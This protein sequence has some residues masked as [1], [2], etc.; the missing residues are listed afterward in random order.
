MIRRLRHYALSAINHI[1]AG[2]KALKDTYC[3]L[4]S[5]RIR[6]ATAN[7]DEMEISVC[8]WL[9]WANN[10]AFRPERR[11]ERLLARQEIFTSAR[12]LNTVMRR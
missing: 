1:L 6:P 5:P 7:D 3:T 12:E 11:T 4:G 2:D 10:L 9:N 8:K